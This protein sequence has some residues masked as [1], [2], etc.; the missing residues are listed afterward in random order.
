MWPQ[1]DTYQAWEDLL[2]YPEF[3]I[4]LPTSRIPAIA[5]LLAAIPD[6][7]FLALRAGVAKYWRAFVWPKSVGGL[8]YDYMIASLRNRMVRLHARQFHPLQHATEAAA[9]G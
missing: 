4:R 3:S 9:I 2:P 5:E 1:D 6:E 8:A 7:D